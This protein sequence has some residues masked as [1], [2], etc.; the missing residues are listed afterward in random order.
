MSV[1]D[2][3]RH[4]PE[5]AERIRRTVRVFI[6]RGLIREGQRGGCGS[7]LARYFGVSRERISQV[8]KDERQARA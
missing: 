1:R 5:R 3:Q 2:R 4:D 6:D 8:V 7:F